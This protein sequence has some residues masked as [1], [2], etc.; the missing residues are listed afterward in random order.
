MNSTAAQ[1]T[2]GTGS[3]EIQY[4]AQ[5]LYLCTHWFEEV[6]SPAKGPITYDYAQVSPMWFWSDRWQAM[7]AEADRDIASGHLSP[8]LGIDQLLSRLDKLERE[9]AE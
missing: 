6:T 8:A 3:D 2:G 4:V 9:G 1:I 7:E 5:A